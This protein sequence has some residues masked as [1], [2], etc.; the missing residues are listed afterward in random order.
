MAIPKNITNEHIIRAIDEIDKN[1]VPDDR[2]QRKFN[3]NLIEISLLPK[4][5]AKYIVIFSDSDV[6]IDFMYWLNS[7]N[8]SLLVQLDMEDIFAMVVVSLTGMT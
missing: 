3:L 7:C 2:Q 6:P 8:N 1:G 4:N 5:L